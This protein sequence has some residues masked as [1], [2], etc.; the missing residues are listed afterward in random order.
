MVERVEELAA[1]LQVLTADRVEPLDPNIC[2]I[3]EID[4]TPD[5]QLFL[6][7]AYYAGE[8]LKKKIERGPLPLDEALE[9]AIQIAQ[10]LVKAHGAGIIHRDLKPANALVTSDGLVKIVDTLSSS[11]MF[12]SD[13][14]VCGCIW[15]TRGSRFYRFTRPR[16]TF[17]RKSPAAVNA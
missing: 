17:H 1:K 2:T 4:E 14:R 13:I 16:S 3:H 6:V 11:R 10:G 5:G 7:M 8:T 9:Y 15:R 12:S